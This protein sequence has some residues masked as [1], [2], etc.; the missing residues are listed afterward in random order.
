MTVNEKELIENVEHVTS[1][2]SKRL[3]AKTSQQMVEVL[4]QIDKLQEIRREQGELLVELRKTLLLEWFGDREK[5]RY[6][7]DGL[8]S[9]RKIQLSKLW[10]KLQEM[11]SRFPPE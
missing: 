10:K 11:A 2:G 7:R 9:L 8:S 1:I 4:Q 3:R 5:E 6:R